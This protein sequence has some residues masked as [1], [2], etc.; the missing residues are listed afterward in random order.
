MS[1]EIKL[2]EYAGFKIPTA[3]S[4]LVE[5]SRTALL[6]IDVQKDLCNENSPLRKIPFDR[7]THDFSMYTQMVKNIKPLLE[8][9]R[10]AGVQV[11]YTKSIRD[12]RYETPYS[13]YFLMKI[14]GKLPSQIPNYVAEGTG[15][16]EIVD[17]LTPL[18]GE[19]VIS[20]IRNSAFFGTLLDSLLRKN[21]ID[22]LVLTGCQ[23]DGCIESTVRDAVYS[24]GYYVVLPEDCIASY[25]RQN[26]EAMMFIFKRRHD[27]V[28]S[29][30][31]IKIWRE[32]A[33]H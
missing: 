3:L 1:V 7:T 22:S 32:S 19:V 8:A 6:V 11:F 20:K 4:E 28:D 18:P 12:P 10:A 5:P 21:R 27:V 25:S 24:I 14:F 13:L 31:I 29:K 9:A 2:I 30:E 23:T 16:E 17:E 26:H 33:K 15:G